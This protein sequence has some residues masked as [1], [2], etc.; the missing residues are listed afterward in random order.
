MHDMEAAAAT[1]RQIMRPG[2]IC[3]SEGRILEMNKFGRRLIEDSEGSLEEVQ[4]LIEEAARRLIDTGENWCH[5]DIFGDKGRLSVHPLTL[6][7]PPERSAIVLDSYEYFR[8]VIRHRMQDY[9]LTP[10]EIEICT[11]LV[12]G[13]SNRDVADMLFIAESTVKEHMT[14]I[15]GKF[16]VVSRNSIVPK[17]LGYDTDS[18][19]RRPND[20]D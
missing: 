6:K 2:Y 14:S 16:D 5:I 13:M 20:R 12:Q 7:N 10:R 19:N 3:D 18:L 9:G 15:L 1:F 17:L 8:R 4:T 11:L